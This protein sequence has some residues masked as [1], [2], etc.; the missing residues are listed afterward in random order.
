MA[1]KIFLMP[2]YSMT[3][4]AI[5]FVNPWLPPVFPVENTGGKVR[6]LT[7]ARGARV[8][9]VNG[10]KLTAQTFDKSPAPNFRPVHSPFT[11]YACDMDTLY[12][13]IGSF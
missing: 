5:D 2:W 8:Y 3:L 13:C 10:R 6:D 1:E 4:V 12:S 7:I 9:S 11:L